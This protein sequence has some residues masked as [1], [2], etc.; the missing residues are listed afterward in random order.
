MRFQSVRAA[1]WRSHAGHPIIP[2]RPAKP[3]HEALKPNTRRTRQSLSPIPRACACTIGTRIGTAYAGINR[4]E[5]STTT[6]VG[7]DF[8][9]E[10]CISGGDQQAMAWRRAH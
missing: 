10:Y 9:Q 3:T 4:E 7:C 6:G 2:P 1:Q 8:P 5:P